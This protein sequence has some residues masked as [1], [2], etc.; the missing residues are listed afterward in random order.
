MAGQSNLS[1]TAAIVPKRLQLKFERMPA[2]YIHPLRLGHCLPAE[3]PEAFRDRLL[4]TPRLQQRLSALIAWKF[5]LPSGG[6]DQLTSSSDPLPCAPARFAML[7]GGALETATRSIGA[8]W[9]R[10]TIAKIILAEP[11]RRLTTWL[12]RDIYREA[13][14]Y[15]AC[16]NAET[17]SDEHPFADTPDIQALCQAIE[18]DGQRC[19]LAWS[20]RQPAALAARL[21]IKLP[22]DAEIDGEP[23]RLFRSLGPAIVEHV[24]ETMMGP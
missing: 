7:E 8:I 12:G 15:G 16:G 24:I 10:Q 6:I 5:T 11:L 17:G 19:V 13:L 20:D 9:H 22:P 14:G 18:R 4:H 21:R 23:A 3:L 2:A 1:A